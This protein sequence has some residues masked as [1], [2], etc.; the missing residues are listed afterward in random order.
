MKITPI[1]Q[2]SILGAILV[3]GVFFGFYQLLLKPKMAE[4]IKLRS[5]LEEKKQ[6]LEEAKKIVAKYVE[7]KKRADTVQR[8]LEWNQ[9]RIPKTIEKTKLIESIGFIQNR[10]G[11]SLTNIAVSSAPVSK[12]AYVEIPVVV[13][14][15]SDFDG[16]LRFLKEI[17]LSSN[18]MM[19][20]RDLMVAPSLS[21]DD[22]NITISAQMTICGVQAK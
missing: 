4:I 10:S 8:E 19:T 3:A 15:S 17:S 21:K 18:F 22:P 20:A 11:V 6:D 9:A 5:T 16:L 1:Q 13:R 7:F 14:I 2:Y 12:D